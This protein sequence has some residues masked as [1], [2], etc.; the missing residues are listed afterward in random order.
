M[1]V[2]SRWRAPM[3]ESVPFYPEGS[4]SMYPTVQRQHHPTLTDIG[5]TRANLSSCSWRAACPDVA[6]G[7]IVGVTRQG[8]PQLSL[9]ARAGL[10]DRKL[11]HVVALNA[12][13]RHLTAEQRRNLAGR[14]PAVRLPRSRTDRSRASSDCRRRPSVRFAMPWK[15][16][17]T[18]P[19]WTRGWTHSAG[20]SPPPSGSRRRRSCRPTRR[21]GT[22][23]GTSST[24]S[25]RRWAAST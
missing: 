20:S 11:V 13:R 9:S 10:T 2:V 25:L 8:S 23:R 14:P 15:Q 17:E 4:D 1:P 12:D 22:R 5:V 21:S 18:C 6:V 19:F 7:E 3:R 24:P 16:P